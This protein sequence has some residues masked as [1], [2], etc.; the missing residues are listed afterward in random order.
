M[1]Q[2]ATSGGGLSVTR[3][4]RLKELRVIGEK[5]QNSAGMGMPAAARCQAE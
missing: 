4:L 2:K 1:P 3:A 5:M